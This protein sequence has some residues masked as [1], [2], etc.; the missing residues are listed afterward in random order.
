MVKKN[1]FKNIRLLCVPPY[2]LRIGSVSSFPDWCRGPL[3]P[4]FPLPP[5]IP[6]QSPL[7]SPALSHLQSSVLPT[8]DLKSFQQIIFDCMLAASRNVQSFIYKSI[9]SKIHRIETRVHGTKFRQINV[10]PVGQLVDQKIDFWTNFVWSIDRL[11]KLKKWQT[12]VRTHNKEITGRV[13]NF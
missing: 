12:D 9:G 2:L 13:G 5:P 6:S 4:P 11:A 3:W 10:W 7:E 1:N 8:V